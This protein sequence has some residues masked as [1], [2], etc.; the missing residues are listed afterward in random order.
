[1]CLRQVSRQD[2]ISCVRTNLQVELEEADGKE[3][4]N[5]K[6]PKGSGLELVGRRLPSAVQVKPSPSNRYRTMTSNSR[7][8]AWP[9]EL[10]S[11]PTYNYYEIEKE[12]VE[13]TEAKPETSLDELI[14]PVARCQNPLALQLDQVSTRPVQVHVLPRLTWEGGAIV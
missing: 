2:D 14:H 11:L 13:L 6:S 12:L 3:E 4:D 8:G 5:R 7:R 9:R 10:A 1:M